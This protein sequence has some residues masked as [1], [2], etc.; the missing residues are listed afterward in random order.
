MKGPGK[1]MLIRRLILTDFS[2]KGIRKFLI[3]RNIDVM[4]KVEKLQNERRAASN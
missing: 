2:S 1:M 4:L 3:E